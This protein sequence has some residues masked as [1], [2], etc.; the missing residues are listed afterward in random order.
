MAYHAGKAY[1]ITGAASGIG[2]ATA[3]ILASHG[4]SVS[5]ADIDRA[6]LASASDAIRKENVTAKIFTQV[7]DVRRRS[8]VASWIKATVQV[9][10]GLDGAVN[11]A[12]IVNPALVGE[13]NVED[14]PDE[15][16]D[17]VIGINLTGTMISITEELKAM[18]SLAGES[19][20]AA[21]HGRSI[22]NATS[23]TGLV[24]KDG[25]SAYS[26]SKHGVIGL[27]KSVAREAAKNM[28]R[29]N[30]IAPYVHF[31]GDPP[32]RHGGMLTLIC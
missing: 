20:E 29:V 28:I 10:G 24:G 15:E 19:G 32:L 9:F 22:V 23:V 13:K 4:A 12:G 5:L 1:A 3:K 2:L 11:M 8:D 26:A 21:E 18:K 17:A 27:T 7:V 30:A 16:W 6:Q 14:V 31:V 25:A